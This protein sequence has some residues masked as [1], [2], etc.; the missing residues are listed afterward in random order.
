MI[1][2]HNDRLVPPE[3]CRLLHQVVPQRHHVPVRFFNRHDAYGELTRRKH[4]GYP[5]PFGIFMHHERPCIGINLNAVYYTATP[6]LR[7][8]LA[9]ST[10]LWRT[11]L[12]V[13]LHEFGHVATR[14]LTDR[15]NRHEYNAEPWGRVY[16]YT[17][18]LAEEWKDERLAQILTYDSRLGQPRRITGYLSVRLA[19]RRTE[20]R[21][22]ITK[23]E[24]VYISGST[25]AAYVKEQR[26]WRTGAQLSAGDILREIGLEPCRFTNAYRLL[27]RASD[28]LGIN[29]R[30]GVGRVH[31]LY[32]WG[33]VPIL[34]E[35]LAA[36][37]A[38]PV[39]RGDEYPASN[40][41]LNT[42]ARDDLSVPPSKDAV[43]WV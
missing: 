10:A 32:T 11:L 38:K 26:C 30:D 15:L 7:P 36:C 23:R 39:Y 35:R 37:K 29:Y 31:R 22:G 43:R 4:R 5:T 9:F 3:L 34:A 41:P 21:K 12:D 16:R 14:A 8:R 18:H 1:E 28:G 27:Y 13:C 17:E 19:K 2:F 25:R 20:A 42:L 24:N 40:A 33:D 6:H